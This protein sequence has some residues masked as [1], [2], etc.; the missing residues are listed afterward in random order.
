MGCRGGG[1]AWEQGNQDVFQTGVSG[2]TRSDPLH[3]KELDHINGGH[4]EPCFCSMGTNI[5]PI[6]GTLIDA[7][8]WLGGDKT[9]EHHQ[10]CAGAERGDE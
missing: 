6:Q 1:N 4:R 2:N 5:F 9:P 10:H 7:E 8:I 3:P